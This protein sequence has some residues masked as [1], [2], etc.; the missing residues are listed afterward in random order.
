MFPPLVPPPSPPPRAD[1]QLH[2]L[3]KTINIEIVL[4]PL[5][6]IKH[7]GPLP[8]GLIGAFEALFSLAED[9]EAFLA[10]HAVELVGGFV[11]VVREV[12]AGPVDCGEGVGG[13]KEGFVVELVFVEAGGEGGGLVEEARVVLGFLGLGWFCELLWKGWLVMG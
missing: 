3:Q 11:F 5:G 9:V 2:L 12:G 1:S 13:A 7:D 10:G 8:L 6:L 4:P